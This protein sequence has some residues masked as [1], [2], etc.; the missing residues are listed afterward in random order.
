M[1]H[2]TAYLYGINPMRYYLICFTNEENESCGG[3]QLSQT[4]TA[5]AGVRLWI[6]IRLAPEA[7]AGFS[8]A[9]AAALW[10]LRNPC[11]THW[12]GWFRG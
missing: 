3:Q 2:V 6:Q 9:I 7:V 4:L 1:N 10:L 12:M 11:M 5:R 8:Y